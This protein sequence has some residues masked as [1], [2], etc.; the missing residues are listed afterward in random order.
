LWDADLDNLF[1]RKYRR[2]DSHLQKRVDT[3]VA[4]I[5]GSEDPAKLGK[6]KRGHLRHFYAYYLGSQY[7]IIYYIS[8]NTKRIIFVNVGSHKEVYGTV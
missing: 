3:A 4:E 6:Q 2:L 1:R 5:V 7:R 8:Y